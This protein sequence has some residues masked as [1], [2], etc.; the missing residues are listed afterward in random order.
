VNL[1]EGWPSPSLGGTLF[2][3]IIVI[4]ILLGLSG[5]ALDH[6][7]AVEIEF[8]IICHT[9]GFIVGLSFAAV[10]ESNY[11]WPPNINLA[12]RWA[13]EKYVVASNALVESSSQVQEEN[14]FNNFS[15]QAEALAKIN[16][17]VGVCDDAEESPVLWTRDAENEPVLLAAIFWVD[18]GDNTQT[19]ECS[20]FGRFKIE[21][22]QL[23]NVF[24]AAFRHDRHK[25]R[26]LIGSR[27]RR[28]FRLPFY[29][30]IAFVEG[31]ST[32]TISWIWLH[33]LLQP[34]ELFRYVDM[35]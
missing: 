28:R 13:E 19:V 2:F 29:K 4:L 17:K 11:E 21:L 18:L 8:Q 23:A 27:E 6:R 14:R 5:D 35:V 7:V 34:P 12:L 20:Q 22:Q 15:C 1:T 25:L 31:P 9:F 32:S 24:H 33:R 30:H 26:A 16:I 10:F 3:A